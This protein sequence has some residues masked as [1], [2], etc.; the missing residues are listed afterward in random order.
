MLAEL[1]PVWELRNGSRG[2]ELNAPAVLAAELRGLR[3]SGGSDDHAG[4]DIGRTWTETQKATSLPTFLAHLRAGSVAPGGVHG[5]ATGWAHAALALSARTLGADGT[6]APRPAAVRVMLERILDEARA[7]E[8]ADR[9]GLTPQDARNV[10]GAWLDEVGM[11]RDAAAL[12]A[13]LQDDAV[14][15]EAVRRRALRAHERLLHQAATRVPS[16]VADGDVEQALGALARAC[17]PVL[18]YVASSAFLAR[19][20]SNLRAPRAAG[21][22]RVALVADGLDGIDGVTTLLDELR[23]RGVPGWEVDVIGTDPHVDRRLP[24]AAEVELPF[25]A[26]R[27]VGVPS[28]MG[29]TEALTSR[30]YALVHACSPGPAGVGAAAIAHLAGL[31]LVISHHTELGRYAAL[32]SGRAD[33]EQLTREGLSAWY[34]QGR[35]VL[36]PSSSADRSLEALGVDGARIARW[37]RGVDPTLFGPRTRDTSDERITVLYAGRLST[38]KGIG[39]LVDAFSMAHVRDSRLHL[40]LAGDGP[41]APLLRSALGAEATFLGWQTREQLAHTYGQADVFCFASCTDTYGQVVAEA[42]ASALPVIA[43]AEGGPVDLVEDG[44]T[45]LLVEPSPIA[46]ADALI[47]LARAPERRAALGRA[48]ARAARTRTWEAAFAQLAA[49]Y[50]AALRE[51]A[52]QELTVAA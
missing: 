22:R 43:V 39:L 2:A 7:R 17:L 29:L 52:R 3:G 4:V 11:P 9:D 14:G 42:Q 31:P 45:G 28:L 46:L 6:G 24:A 49:G 37:T 36:S 40:V 18:P 51:P 38:E 41:E 34:A 8:G 25:Y 47:E 48:A 19:E 12:I 30:P 16:A 26:G 21:T 15:H 20:R 35:L 5:G 23:V 44:V 50:E 27:R 1:F 33:L 32:R 13:M 10:F